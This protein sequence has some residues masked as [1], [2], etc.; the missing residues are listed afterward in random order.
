MY[1][2]VL[3]PYIRYSADAK[4][5]YEDEVPLPLLPPNSVPSVDYRKVMTHLGFVDLAA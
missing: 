1:S 4:K 3:L 5:L 2:F